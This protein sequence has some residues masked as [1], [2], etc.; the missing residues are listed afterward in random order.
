MSSW[1][2]TLRTPDGD[3]MV[4]HPESEATHGVY[5][6]E[7]GVK[8][9]IIDAPIKKEYDST[10]LQEGGTDRGTDYEWRDIHLAFHIT[11]REMS[12]EQADSLLAL[13]FDVEEDEWDPNTNRQTVLDLET[14]I[15]GVRSLDLMIAETTSSEF[16]HDPIIDQYFNPNFHLRAAQPMWYEPTKI[17]SLDFGPGDTDGV[18][19]VENRTNRPMRHTWV[20]SGGIGTQVWL[21][22]VSWVGPKGGRVIAGPY[23]D[24]E[25]QLPTIAAAH[26]GGFRVTLDR[27]K[28]MVRDK[29]D[30]NVLGQMPV[31]GKIFLHR[32]PHY[33]RRTPLPVKIRNAPAEGGRIELH[34]PQL[35]TRPFGLEMW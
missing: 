2:V 7:D 12:A 24:R 29:G 16:S 35:W 4:V 22:D 23:A 25:I 8:G 31:P 3:E 21:P 17:A 32:I 26:D 9:D 10:A 11:D 6:A 27:G 15:S 34:M 18:V 5:L 13:K 33:T 28:I 19:Y 14:E 1:K 20:V 30:T